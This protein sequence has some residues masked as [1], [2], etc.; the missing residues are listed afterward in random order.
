MA[1]MILLSSLQKEEE[2][3]GEGGTGGGDRL[4]HRGDDR[5]TWGNRP[6]LQLVT[7]LFNTISEL[8]HK[9]RTQ[10]Y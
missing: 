9:L 10:S 3:L 5:H 6:G 2:G 8:T 7:I 1:Y 4:A